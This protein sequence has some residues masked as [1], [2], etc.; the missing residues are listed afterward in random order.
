MTLDY[1]TQIKARPGIVLDKKK[2][3][4][5]RLPLAMLGKVYCKVE[6]SCSRIQV[7][8]MLTTSS[9]PGHVM[10]ASLRGL[11]GVY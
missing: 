2:S 8:D 9:T 3:T 7:G 1:L 4:N 5:F 10:K 11:W 6:A